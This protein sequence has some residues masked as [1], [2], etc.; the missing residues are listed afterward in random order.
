MNR[1]HRLAGAIALAFVLAPAAGGVSRAAQPL[2]AP[3]IGAAA[4]RAI[5]V[6]MR[7][8]ATGAQ[9]VI[10]VDRICYY[11]CSAM[12]ITT[13]AVPATELCPDFIDR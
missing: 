8:F 11:R 6:A 7:C 2:R 9:R 13:I 1:W 5:P 10:G 3:M 12:T 4:P